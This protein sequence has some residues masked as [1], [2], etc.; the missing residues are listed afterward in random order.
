MRRREI[1]VLLAV[2]LLAGCLMVPG[3]RGSGTILV[4]PLPM[5]VVLEEEPYY[6]HGGYF[7][8][9]ENNRWSYSNSRGGPWVKLPRDRYPKEVKFKGKGNDKDK[10]GN[11][12]Q[13]KRDGK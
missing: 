2:S 13:D 8:F 12:G 1:A 5:I 6:Q 10:G 11:R 4:P 3:P 9:Y 7:Y